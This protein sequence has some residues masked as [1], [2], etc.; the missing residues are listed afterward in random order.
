M[1]NI[2][3]ITRSEAFYPNAFGIKFS[4]YQENP[5][6]ASIIN[7]DWSEAGPLA[8]VP[9]MESTT[10]M[11]RP[12]SAT[13]KFPQSVTD[14]SGKVGFTV[15]Q[16]YPQ[17]IKDMLCGLLKLEIITGSAVTG[18]NQ[19]Y[20][21][22]SFTK[23]S[24]IPFDNQ[25]YSGGSLGSPSSVIVKQD[26][27][28]TPVT[29]ANNDDYEI[30]RINGKWGILL[31]LGGTFDST[32]TL[33]ITYSYTPAAKQRLYKT[34]I[35]EVGNIM[36]MAYKKVPSDGSTNK[37]IEIYYP[38]CT[39]TK[40]FAIKGQSYDSSEY[41]SV[42]MEF[43]SNLHENFLYDDKKVLEFAEFYTV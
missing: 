24:F 17:D 40:D 4:P 25:N 32:D 5:T 38:Y 36:L 19:Q 8:D 37:Y 41:N 20:P 3:S 12:K 33:Q 29:L 14:R 13:Y 1:G 7:A 22:N 16:I 9:S 35:T 26:Y 43:E 28:G 15:Q 21:A 31:C 11:E 27:A 23:G 42:P 39:P 18:Y 30:I 34:E 6:V 10:K 2:S